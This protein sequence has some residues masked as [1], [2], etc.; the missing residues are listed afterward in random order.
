MA[1]KIISKLEA[2][3]KD[4]NKGILKILPYAEKAEPEVDALVPSLGPAYNSTVTAIALAEQNAAAVGSAG[5]AANQSAAVISIVGNLVQS[6]LKAAGQPATAADVEKY[7]N[8]VYA[9]LS[10]APSTAPAA[11]ASSAAAA[12][13][14]PAG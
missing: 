10:T 1:S 2:I 12:A 11:P 5:G 8:A 4:F 14:T 9:V 3:A 6:E 13:P 7:V